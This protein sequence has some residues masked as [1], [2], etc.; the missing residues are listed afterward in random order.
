[1][2]HI[3]LNMLDNYVHV[4][5]AERFGDLHWHESIKL[6]ARQCLPQYASLPW[7]RPPKLPVVVELFCVRHEYTWGRANYGKV[8]GSM[9]VYIYTYIS[10]Q[11]SI[12]L[13]SLETVQLPILGSATD[14]RRVASLCKAGSSNPCLCPGPGQV[15]DRSRQIPSLS[16][17]HRRIVSW[18]PGFAS[19]SRSSRRTKKYFE[20]KHRSS[21]GNVVN[22]AMNFPFGHIPPTSG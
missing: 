9:C 19:G 18:A 17:P 7:L 13:A 4:M 5:F 21:W 12:E 14:L 1:M 6:I 22:P 20:G 8:E 16:L 10:L 15:K 2:F 11:L 3:V